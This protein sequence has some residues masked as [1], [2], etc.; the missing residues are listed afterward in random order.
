MKETNK[1]FMPLVLLMC[2]AGGIVGAFLYNLA[3]SQNIIYDRLVS[4]SLTEISSYTLLQRMQNTSDHFIMLDVRDKASYDL[5]H[6]KG[7]IS[8]PETDIISRYNELPRDEDIILYCWSSECSLGPSAA[9]SLAELDFTNLKDLKIGWCEWSER[10]Y[11]IDGTR[12]ILKG[13]CMV[14]QRSISNETVKVLDNIGN[15]QTCIA[16]AKTC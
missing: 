4:N 15:S 2:I 13:E 10:G 8:I 9:A 3:F 11:P 16:G 6:I 12:Y 14:P 1:A 5:G 7:A